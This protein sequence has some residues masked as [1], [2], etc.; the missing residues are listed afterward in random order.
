MMLGE[1]RSRRAEGPSRQKTVPATAPTTMA[2]SWPMATGS[3]TT[4]ITAAAAM[5]A[6]R[7]SGH[8]VRAMPMTACATTATATSL[9]PCTIA[10]PGGVES[11]RPAHSARAIIRTAEGAVNPTQAHHAAPW[12][13]A[14]QTERDAGLAG[15][16]TGKKLAKP[17][18]IGVLLLVEPPSPADE[19][20][21]EVPDMGHR[22]PRTRCSLA[23]K[24]R[25]APPTASH[26]GAEFASGA[27]P[28]SF[29]HQDRGSSMIYDEACCSAEQHLWA[30]IMPIGTHQNERCSPVLGF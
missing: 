5:L 19:L 6:R 2:A 15:G 24:T 1:C 21:P 17:D 26:H 4:R 9:S 30:A 28:G 16:R 10:A 13:R 23:S 3:S 25:A 12:A 14:Q 7:G 22:P 27:R 8:S 29:R 11:S 20:G 18:E